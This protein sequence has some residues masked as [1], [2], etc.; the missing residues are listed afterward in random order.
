M[1]GRP[2]DTQARLLL[3]GVARGYQKLLKAEQ[4]LL[5]EVESSSSELEHH[6]ID[7]DSEQRPDECEIILH[8]ER[9]QREQS[10]ATQRSRHSQTTSNSQSNC[11]TSTQ[12]NKR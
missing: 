8:Q 7:N 1:E 3:L 2:Q 12:A 6:D 4:T 10:V 9:H 11:E 5:A